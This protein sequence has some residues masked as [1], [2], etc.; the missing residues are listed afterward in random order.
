M[1]R[2][3]RR[4]YHYIYKTTCTITG[5]YYIG[6]HSTDNLEDGYVGSG[7]R[8]WYS[9]NK[10]GKENH[11]CEILEH[12]FTREWLREREAELVCEERLTDPL[13]MNLKVGGEG[14]F[15]HVNKDGRNN[16]TKTKEVLARGAKST[17][18]RLQN[19]EILL[20]EHKSRSAQNMR[21]LH[22]AGKLNVFISGSEAQKKASIASRTDEANAKRKATMAERNHQVGAA[23]NQYGT[24]WIYKDSEKKSMKISKDKLSLFLIDG[25]IKGRRMF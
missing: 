8:L 16:S 6:M 18:S 24:C 15:D 17:W 3:Y 5:K 13:C 25:W 9:I 1:K 19:N 12:Y 14:G 21:D 22:A 10:H 2:A 11:V 7:K 4:R 20:A 23:N